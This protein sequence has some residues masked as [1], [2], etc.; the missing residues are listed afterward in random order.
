MLGLEPFFKYFQEHFN[1][2]K[3]ETC[4]IGVVYLA[5]SPGSWGELDWNRSESEIVILYSISECFNY[6]ICGYI[7]VLPL[8]IH[9][10]HGNPGTLSLPLSEELRCWGFFWFNHLSW[11]PHNVTKCRRLATAR[12]NQKYHRNLDIFSRHVC[13][14]NYSFTSY[15][16]REHPSNLT[17]LTVN[18][19]RMAKTPGVNQWRKRGNLTLQYE[20]RTRDIVM[21]TL[22]EIWRSLLLAEGSQE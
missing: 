9:L 20:M 14:N 19:A 1:A 15:I 16:A 12:F 8:I 13:V 7:I 3:S 21:L 11:K 10:I 5:C 18:D 2:L 4:D 22:W 17:K 6:W